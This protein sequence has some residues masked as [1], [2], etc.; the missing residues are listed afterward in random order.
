MPRRVIPFVPN[1]YY[2]LYNR[3]NNRQKIFFERDNYLHF[4]AGIKKNLCNYMDIIA[5]CL[6]LTHYHM[7]VRIK[8]TVITEKET[9]EVL[10]TSE[11][12]VSNMVSNAMQKL[13]ISYTKAINNQF[14]RTGS[15]FQG[16]FRSKLIDKCDYLLRLCVYIHANPVKD[17][18]VIRPED[19]EFSNYKE[20]L[21][22]RQGNL[23]D[24]TFINEQFGSIEIYKNMVLDFLKTRN[25]TDDIKIYII[26][27]R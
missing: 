9:S 21:Y 13:M 3:G 18:L 7:L 25:I 14:D 17:S 26:D 12:L 16:Q 1:Q 20:W 24:R 6:M 23:V 4:L 19:W 22:L 2:H 27:E 10:K 8:D 11:I 5:Y 15:L